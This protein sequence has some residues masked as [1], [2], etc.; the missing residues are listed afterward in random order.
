MTFSIENKLGDLLTLLKH[1][2]NH[3]TNSLDIIT[4]AQNNMRLVRINY[5]K[6]FSSLLTLQQQCMP[7][8]QEK[9]QLVKLSSQVSL[10]KK[11]YMD[12][13]DLRHIFQS[14]TLSCS[15]Q[16][17]SQ[18][19]TR[20]EECLAFFSANKNLV[21]SQ[22]YITTYQDHLTKGFRVITKL[23]LSC[24][25]SMSPHAP[26]SDVL[27][28]YCSVIVGRPFAVKHLEEVVK[29]YGEFRLN[30]NVV[31]QTAK[32]LD[33]IFKKQSFVQSF[34]FVVTS[35][36]TIISSRIE[37]EFALAQRNLSY[38][39]LELPNLLSFFLNSIAQLVN[40]YLAKVLK[41]C[42][43]SDSCSVVCR[44]LIDAIDNYAVNEVLNII[45]VPFI[46][47]NLSNFKSKLQNF[48]FKEIGSRLALIP[49]DVTDVYPS[50]LL[51]LPDDVL[52]RHP[53]ILSSVS[54]ISRNCRI[55]RTSDLQSIASSA[56]N[57]SLATLR[58]S[59]DFL[60]H[61][62][63]E[64]NSNLYLLQQII[65]FQQDLNPYKD[66]LILPIV[67][68]SNS[69]SLLSGF[70]NSEDQVSSSSHCFRSIVAFLN[71]SRFFTSKVIVKLSFGG[72]FI[73]LLSRFQCSS[74]EIQSDLI[75]DV[76]DLALQRI[77]QFSYIL[78]CCTV[79][80]PLYIRSFEEVLDL[81]CQ[82]V[83]ALLDKINIFYSWKEYN[84][85]Q[86]QLV[87][88]ISRYTENSKRFEEELMSIF[89]N[90]TLNK[91]D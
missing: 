88:L 14:P 35:I 73:E 83:S 6:I 32:D 53:V 58:K 61:H 40:E 69:S 89:L 29:K 46:K 28:D 49:E 82:V 22:Q 26:I 3:L 52:P 70:F 8:L 12:A 36:C 71:H 34:D 59:C 10:V 11:F 41:S 64:I 43:S 17:F 80:I 37:A 55:L 91:D 63:D 67:N 45:L 9:D 66:E 84:V 87:E 62:C 15:V 86:I 2:D 39:L 74:T 33:K 44:V 27:S 13:K 85:D 25:N 31:T 51:D 57:L 81:T 42:Q 4:D 76:F 75:D 1:K 48:S 47:Q 65:L 50:V 90:K 30:C 56:V 72:D 16:E 24:I 5:S 7:L 54:L 77:E 79:L 78:N 21:A 18:A 20:C 19:L 60:L 23:A 38:S 68:N